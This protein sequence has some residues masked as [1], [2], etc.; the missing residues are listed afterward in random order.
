MRTFKMYNAREI[1]EIGTNLLKQYPYCIA[2]RKYE[3]DID[4]II[5]T[6]GIKLLF[7][8]GLLKRHGVAAL[9]T[10]SGLAIVVDQRC[11]DD[12]GYEKMLRFTLAE[13]LAH[14]ILHSPIARQHTVKDRISL[15]AFMERIPER[16]VYQAD[17]N[18][19]KLAE[20]IL[21]P[22]SG[23]V[24]RFHELKTELHADFGDPDADVLFQLTHDFNLNIKPVVYR[25]SNL[26][27]IS[28][29]GVILNNLA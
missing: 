8:Y 15:R 13:E 14:T 17:R 20:V 2:G 3:V 26:S 23:F 12:I 22:K 27:L 11:Y 16:E 19:R 10:V 29:S 18:A 24:E 28:D 25:A 7:K 5:S 21:M 6:R 4:R 1:E 9:A